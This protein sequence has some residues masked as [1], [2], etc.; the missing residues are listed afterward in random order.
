MEKSPDNY[1][2]SRTLTNSLGAWLLPPPTRWKWFYSVSEDRV[3]AK[4]GAI[5]QPYRKINRRTGARRGLA[6]YEILDVL[7]TEPPSDLSIASIET[8]HSSTI[9]LLS[10]SSWLEIPRL[11]Q[12]F[13]PQTLEDARQCRQSAD[14][15]AISLLVSNDNGQNLADAI[16][17]G[18]AYG[19]S[20]GSY[21]DARGTSTFLIEG[22]SGKTNRILGVNK[23]PGDPKEQS[24]YRAELGGIVGILAIV[25]CVV[26]VHNITKGKIKVGLDGEQ[27][28]LNAGGDW[29]LKPGQPDF[30]MLQDIRSKIENPPFPGPF[31]GLRA[32]RTVKG[33]PLTLGLS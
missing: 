31:S 17:K 29:P 19:V 27:A 4:Q 22:D 13:P 15:W 32:T 28:M 26:Q 24:S 18:S 1:T 2:S 30:D 6:Y 8:T 11:S 33:N 14:K 10:T 16:Q 7:T 20:D 3:Y 5:W 25:D 23:I 21:K 12:L 9:K